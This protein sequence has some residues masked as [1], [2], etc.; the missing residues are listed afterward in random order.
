MLTLAT[1]RMFLHVSSY[2]LYIYIYT[3]IQ[4]EQTKSG[5]IS[6]SIYTFLKKFQEVI[7]HTAFYIFLHIFKLLF[8]KTMSTFDFQMATYY[9]NYKFLKIYF[10]KHFQ[11]LI[12]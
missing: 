11:V 7:C 6:G 5:Y 9:L 4:N 8:F 10:F 3:E 12:H 2:I 1:I